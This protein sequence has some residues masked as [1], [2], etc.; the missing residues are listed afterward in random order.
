MSLIH[1][2]VTGTGRPPI[3]FVHGFGCAH[4]DWDAQVAHLSP[5]HQTIAVDLRGHG[6]SPGTAAECS[7]ERYGADVAEVMRALAL[8]PAVL[9]GHSM[10]CRIVVEA[11]LQAPALTAG[12]ILVDGSQFSAVMEPVLNARFATP[13]GYVTFIAA[14]F[15]DMFGARSDKAMAASVIERATRLPRPVGEKMMTDMLR[16]DIGRLTGSLASLRVPVMALQTTYSNEKRER[17]GIR[18][19]QTTPYLDM[20]RASVSSVRVEIIEDTGHFPQLEESA[21]TNDLIDS[22][23]AGFAAN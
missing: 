14:L 6:K 19:G 20:L 16:Y 15:R 7:V 9:V 10:G 23:I 5:R 1:Y 2:V 11:A 13:D 17:V 12:I 3:V 22:F 18:Q 4:S 21:R 8:S